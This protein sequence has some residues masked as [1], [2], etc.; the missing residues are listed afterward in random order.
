MWISRH[1]CSPPAPRS[2]L[3]LTRAAAAVEPECGAHFQSVLSH[4]EF[5]GKSFAGPSPTV[6]RRV[7]VC[8]YHRP[9]GTFR[10]PAHLTA[11][12]CN[13]TA[14]TQPAIGLHG[15]AHIWQKYRG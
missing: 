1:W 11:A 4:A 8:Q 15:F 12:A 7:H 13:L 6:F 10:S 9:V 14:P 3:E 2:Q 5:C